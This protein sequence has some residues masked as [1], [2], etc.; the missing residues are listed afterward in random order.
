MKLS[1]ITP[2]ILTRDEEANIGRTLEAL[3][4]ADAIVVL[5]SGSN[6]RTEKICR[7]NPRINWIIRDFDTHSAQWNAGLA[8]ITTP[9]VLT[10]DADYRFSP[11][12]LEE[13]RS[14]PDHPDVAGYRIPFFYCVGGTPLKHSLLPPRIALF[15]TSSG[16]YRQDG[17]TQDLQ[18][19][20][21]CQ[22][23]QAA[24]WHDDRKPFHRWWEAQRR[25]A[26][27]EAQ[28]I[29]SVPWR[30]LGW[31]D[32]LR[33]LVFP[34]PFAVAAYCLLIQGLL[35]EGPKGWWYTLQRVL[36]ECALSRALLAGRQTQ[37][38]WL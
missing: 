29:R 23:L 31:P 37:S 11:E 8:R 4:W 14:L 3:D 1:A 36:A 15:R 18:L 7:S 6:D 21:T 12:L 20:G 13:I 16:T 32:R 30:L 35:W 28:K 38:G 9:W 22:E 5:D 27:L 24:L 26:R 10:L 17:H 33:R 2:L 34:A 19:D 25:Y